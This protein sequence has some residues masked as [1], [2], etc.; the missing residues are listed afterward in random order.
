MSNS[1]ATNVEPLPRARVIAWC[2]TFILETS[3]IILGNAITIAIFSS[4]K[5]KNQRSFLLMMNLAVSD[6]LIGAVALP[7]YVYH[8]G[9]HPLHL[10]PTPYIK[11]LVNTFSGSDMVLGFSSLLSLT[12]ISLERLIAS[13]WPVTYR[14]LRIK[15]YLITIALIWCLAFSTGIFCVASMEANPMRS[16]YVSMSLVSVLCLIICASY[17]QIWVGLRRRRKQMHRTRKDVDGRLAVTLL[18]VTFCS[19][20]TWLPFVI[21][22]LYYQF[23]EA[24]YIEEL[25]LFSKLLHYGNSLLNPIVYTFRVPG[26]RKSAKRILSLSNNKRHRGNT[27]NEDSGHA[28]SPT[29]DLDRTR[30]TW[31]ELS[32]PNTPHWLDT[33]EIRI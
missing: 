12:A 16:T 23:T 17:A 20:G 3:L 19:L 33:A 13:S 32:P 27:G 4:K 10:W 1:T 5:Q 30:S 9:I 15:T 7:L 28:H 29:F 24:P 31:G 22:N 11:G 18:I 8:A 2:A 14:G 25:V 6:L 26:F 21:V